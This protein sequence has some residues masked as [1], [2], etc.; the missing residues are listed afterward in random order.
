VHVVGGVRRRLAGVSGVVM[1]M[2]GVEEPG[3]CSSTCCH[4]APGKGARGLW[5][6]GVR[7][8]LCG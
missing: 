3:P 6:P 8:Q 7:K 5:P 1:F 4:S 2:G